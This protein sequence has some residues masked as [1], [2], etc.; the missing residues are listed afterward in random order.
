[1]ESVPLGTTDDG[2]NKLDA[3]PVGGPPF[4]LALSLDNLGLNKKR[5]IVWN[6][7]GALNF[8]RCTRVRKIANYAINAGS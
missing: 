8:K 1:M 6:A 7:H 5:E 3:D 2:S 4:D